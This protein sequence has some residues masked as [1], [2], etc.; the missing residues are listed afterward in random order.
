[1][2]KRSIGYL[3]LAVLLG[4]GL[5][6]TAIATTPLKDQVLNRPFFLQDQP[7]WIMSRHGKMNW[8]RHYGS[9]HW[10]GLGN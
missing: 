3:V 7:S 6:Y 1:M 4:S 5:T 8:G 10:H 2:M 9:G